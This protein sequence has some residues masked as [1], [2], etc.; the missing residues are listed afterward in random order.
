MIANVK[1]VE[2]WLRIN[3]LEWWEIRTHDQDNR[4]VYVTESSDP[5]ETRFSKFRDNM[6]LSKG[7]RYIIYASDKEN[8]SKKGRYREEFANL[9]TEQGNTPAVTGLGT[10]PDGY[11]SK[12]EF[13]ALKNELLQD[14][15]MQKLEDELKELKARNKELEDPKEELIRQIAPYAMPIIQG[16]ATK[17]FPAVAGLPAQIEVQDAKEQPNNQHQKMIEEK[18]FVESEEMTEDETTR[19]NAAL[20]KWS[21]ADPDFLMCLEIIA[22]MAETGEKIDA[23]LIQ[24]GYFDVKKMLLK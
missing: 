7:G 15:K 5:L 19:L 8:G 13:E 1:D 14:I 21:N 6:R 24:I 4:L 3:M 10:I 22:N 20:E 11:I 2:E 16:F 17:F 18:I 9:G 12:R 23:G